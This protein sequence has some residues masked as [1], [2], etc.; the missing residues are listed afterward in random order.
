MFKIIFSI[1]DSCKEPR[2]GQLSPTYLESSLKSIVTYS[3]KIQASS[4]HLASYFCL[5]EPG[6]QIQASGSAS[7]SIC[8]CVLPLPGHLS[9]K[10]NKLYFLKQFQV[11][12]KTEEKLQRIPIY[13][14]PPTCDIP[15]HSDTL[16]TTDELTLSRHYCPKSAVYIRVDS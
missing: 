7:L 5:P 4:F 3:Q 15:H 14:L 9:L 13:L 10:N 12:I 11:L 2:P 16:F 6:L 1:L 8:S